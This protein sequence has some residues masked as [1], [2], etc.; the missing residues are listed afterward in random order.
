MS[1]IETDQPRTAATYQGPVREHLQGLR[2]AIAATEQHVTRLEEWGRELAARLGSGQRL[3]VAGNGGSAA[4]AQHLT[5]ELV[6][7]Y[8][9]DRPAY[10][11][12]ALSAESSSVTAIG[13]DY[14]FDQVFA[15]QVHAHGRPGDVV[16]LI[17]TSGRSP[18]L[19]RAAEA[20]RQVGAAVW[21]LTGPGPNP[22]ADL[23]DEAICIDAPS[24][25]VQECHLVAIHAV[26]C[27][28]D[29]QIRKAEESA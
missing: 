13:N 27:V 23:A 10:S 3:L 20:A 21:S 16:L 26:C 8:Q 17:S 5:A 7:R 19:L 18:N 25:H 1:I 22:L 29:E 2:A 12:L 9:H 28:F 11:A 4:E 15:R 14:G 24:P 6:G